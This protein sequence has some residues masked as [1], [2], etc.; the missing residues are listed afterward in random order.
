MET[1]NCVKIN[2]I[3]NY[4]SNGLVHVTNGVLKPVTGSLI[5]LIQKNP[6]LSI[7]KTGRKICNNVCEV[8]LN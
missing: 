4:A 5:E 8:L 7:M 1:A 6:E 2:S 3:D